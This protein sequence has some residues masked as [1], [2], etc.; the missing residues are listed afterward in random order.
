[1]DPPDGDAAGWS[2]EAKLAG[3]AE[4]LRGHGGKSDR[5]RV[6]V[7]QVVLTWVEPP[8]LVIET[9]TPERGLIRSERE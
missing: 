3:R 5:F 8:V 2:G 6:D 4:E 9:W 7:D 1:V